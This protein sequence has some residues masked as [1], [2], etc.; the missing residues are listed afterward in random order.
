MDDR[1]HAELQPIALRCTACDRPVLFVLDSPI[2]FDLRTGGIRY[3]KGVSNPGHAVGGALCETCRLE[4]AKGTDWYEPLRQELEKLQRIQFDIGIDRRVPAT[5]QR[6]THELVADRVDLKGFAVTSYGRWYRPLPPGTESLVNG[7][8]IGDAS[9][10]AFFVLF[11]LEVIAHPAIPA[12]LHMLWNP[13]TGDSYPAIVNQ[14]EA[15]VTQLKHLM[16]G[17]SIY[18]ESRP[19][20]RPTNSGYDLAPVDFE[21][22][23][24]A[25]YHQCDKLPTKQAV[26]N[27]IVP[28]MDPDTVSNHLARLGMGTW[29]DFKR[30]RL[31]ML[32]AG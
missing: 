21:R 32:N 24:D 22:A 27:A 17:L 13:D 11:A 25:V 18:R 3:T 9:G 10:P 15:T 1:T 28:G 12:E 14:R 29:Y 8:H 20:H 6:F 4:R 7:I 30:K 31:A 5:F 19:A 16:D 26:A 2:R 23:F